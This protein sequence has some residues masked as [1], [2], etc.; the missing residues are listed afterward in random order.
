MVPGSDPARP[1]CVKIEEIAAGTGLSWVTALS[2][3]E[4]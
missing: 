2:S 4:A 1:Q 3:G